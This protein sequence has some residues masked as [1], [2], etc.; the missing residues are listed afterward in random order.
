MGSQVSVLV[1]LANFQRLSDLN[2]EMVRSIGPRTKLSAL[3]AL[4]YYCFQRNCAEPAHITC[5]VLWKQLGFLCVYLLL[6]LVL[7]NMSILEAAVPTETAAS[8]LTDLLS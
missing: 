3:G 1:F 4:A 6:V 5:P 8:T 2:S 7:I